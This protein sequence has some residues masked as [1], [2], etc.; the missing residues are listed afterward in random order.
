VSTAQHG[1]ALDGAGNAV[2]AVTTDSTDFPTTP[3]AYQ[4]AR[5]GNRNICVARI[6][7]DGTKLLASTYF[8]G[9][10]AGGYEPSGLC[11]DAWGNLF[12]SGS[13]FGG[14][15]NH[16][17][18]SDAFSRTSGGQ[19]EAFL[20]IFSPDLSEL[21]YSSHFGGFGNDR[22][23]DLARSASGD[24]VFAGDTYSTDLPIS[25]NAFQRAYRGAGDAYVARFTPSKLPRGDVHDDDQVDFRDLQ[26]LA[27]VWLALPSLE[28]DLTGDHRTDLS[29]YS[30][31][32]QN[33]RQFYTPPG[34]RF[35]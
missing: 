29:D 30:F 14:I 22:I 12:L 33:W 10:P 13:I 26:A 35:R 6:S 17:V 3:D 4:G 11:L 15:S 32:A 20:A 18:T 21:R 8:G 31:M 34:R 16:P 7:S 2:V 9:S 23:R 1:I 27:E 28:S 25:G 5:K 19:D 24:L